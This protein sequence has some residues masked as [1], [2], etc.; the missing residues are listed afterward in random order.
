MACSRK[1]AGS[2]ISTSAPSRRNSARALPVDSRG[3]RAVTQP[4]GPGVPSLATAAAT[5]SLSRLRAGGAAGRQPDQCPAGVE[6]VLEAGQV[7]LP[8]GGEV[9]PWL[10]VEAGVI[11]PRVDDL[12]DAVGAQHAVPARD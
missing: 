4:S 7:G 9:E 2:R 3:T 5:G 10:G 12:I 1:S 6:L 8:V 11:G